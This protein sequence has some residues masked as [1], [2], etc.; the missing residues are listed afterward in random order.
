MLTSI[1]SNLNN[2]AVSLVANCL[3]VSFSSGYLSFFICFLPYRLLKFSYVFNSL[4]D[5]PNSLKKSSLI[6][7]VNCLDYM[8][9]SK[10]IRRSVNVSY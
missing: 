2:D 1:S 3:N 4:A 7:I 8:C 9:L 10:S 6:N 5:L